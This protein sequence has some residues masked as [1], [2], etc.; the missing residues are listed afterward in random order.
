MGGASRARCGRPPGTPRASPHRAGPAGRTRGG[1]APARPAIAPVPSGRRS[2]WPSRWPRRHALVPAGG[3]AARV[4]IDPIVGPVE[5]DER[6]TCRGSGPSEGA[7]RPATA[8]SRTTSSPCS[9]ANRLAMRAPPDMPVTERRGLDGANTS[10]RWSTAAARKAPSAE[11]SHSNPEPRRRLPSGNA[12]TAPCSESGAIRLSRI[13]PSGLERLPCRLS[14]TMDGVPA[15]WAT[16][17]RRRA[18]PTSMMCGVTSKTRKRYPRVGFSA[19]AGL[20]CARP[21]RLR[22]TDG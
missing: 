11:R 17:R 6:G 18:P 7:R 21:V 14:S 2:P 15:G 12:T 4:G 13:W 8:P 19:H 16:S 9:D 22:R 20:V 5:G 1:S 3:A 10:R